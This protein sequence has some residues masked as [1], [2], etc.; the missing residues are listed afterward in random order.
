MHPVESGPNLGEMWFDAATGGGRRPGTLVLDRPHYARRSRRAPKMSK[1]CRTIES[2]LGSMFAPNWTPGNMLAEVAQCW[3]KNDQRQ[4]TLIDV[5]GSIW[6][7]I[8]LNSASKYSAML[9]K[10]DKTVGQTRPM[11]DEFG[12]TLGP[13]STFRGARPTTVRQPRGNL[14]LSARL[15]LSKAVAIT[16]VLYI[17]HYSSTLE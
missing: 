15:G 11:L 2:C 8:H 14:I 7:R 9:A 12:P 4:P 3:P 5:L 1:N 10:L 17:P 13:E 16:S 6:A